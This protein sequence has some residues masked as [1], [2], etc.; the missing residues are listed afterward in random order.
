MSRVF[1]GS[2]IDVALVT[3]NTGLIGVGGAI[4]IVIGVGCAWQIRRGEHLGRLAAKNKLQLDRL[5]V[6]TLDALVW[7]VPLELSLVW[8]VPG[9]YGGVSKCG[10][11]LPKKA[12]LPP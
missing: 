3:N 4:G 2:R 7:A 12:L 6:S 1:A 10:A 11:S 8:A 5:P 9:R